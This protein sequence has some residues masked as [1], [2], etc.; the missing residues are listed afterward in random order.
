MLSGL[1]TA[2]PSFATPVQ[3]PLEILT[4]AE[5][6]VMI[7]F[8]NSG[9]MSSAMNDSGG[10][11]SNRMQ[12]AKDAVTDLIEGFDNVR[13]C[14]SVF[15]HYTNHNTIFD[16]SGAL[17]ESDME[18]T[19]DPVGKA[20]M[21]TKIDSLVADNSTQLS[22]SFYDITRYFRNQPAYFGTFPPGYADPVQ[23]RCQNNTVIVVT[24]GEPQL[25]WDRR[26]CAGVNCGA[27]VPINMAHET[28]GG[29]SLPDWDGISP[30]DTPAAG[31][32]QFSDGLCGDDTA[33]IAGQSQFAHSLS[34]FL[35]DLALFAKETDIKP[36][37]IDDA[38]ESYSDVDFPLQNIQTHTIGFNID[39]QNLEDAAFYGDGKYRSAN[40]EG[41]LVEA[42]E[43]AVLSA[44]SGSGTGAG[45]ASSGVSLVA[46]ADLDVYVTEYDS[47]NWEGEVY[48]YELIEDDV[49][50]NLSTSLN[51]KA[52][53]ELPIHSSRAL[54]T[55][56]ED[57]NAAVKFSYASLSALQK[58]TLHINATEAN[59]IV[60]YLRGDPINE[61]ITASSYRERLGHYLGDTVHSRPAYVKNDGY[62]YPDE[63]YA[64]FK[65]AAA[66]TARDGMVFVGAND[67]ILHA[68][69]ATTGKEKFGYVPNAV[70]KNL[71]SLSKIEYPKNH[72]Y[73]VDGLPTTIDAKLDTNN[74]G[75]YDSDDDWQTL[76]SSPFGAGAKGLFLLNI[77]DPP[78]S[79]IAIPEGDTAKF[80]EIYQWELNE[81]TI[82]SNSETFDDLGYILSQAKIA[83]VRNAD[84]TEHWFLITGNGVHSENGAAVVYILDLETGDLY[85]E[86]VLDTG[87]DGSNDPKYDSL[88]DGNGATD[89]SA[90][91]IDSDSVADRLYITTL[92]GNVWRFDYDGVNKEFRTKYGTVA[93]P[94]PLFTAQI[95]DINDYNRDTNVSEIITQAITGGVTVSPGPVDDA[96]LGGVLVSFGTGRYFDRADLS[97]TN[98]MKV[99][100]FYTVWDN[101]VDHELTRNNL[102]AQSISSQTTDIP[103]SKEIRETTS[104]PIDWIGNSDRGWYLDLTWD[105]GERIVSSPTTFFERIIFNSVVPAK[106]IQDIHGSL[107]VSTSFIE[108]YD[109]CEAGS[110]G[111]FMQI[112]RETG[113][114]PDIASFEDQ[115]ASVTGISSVSGTH[116]PIFIQHKD[117]TVS[118]PSIDAQGN[119]NDSTRVT[120]NL[121]RSSWR[122]LL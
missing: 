64:T 56:N 118:Y 44:V 74:D 29:K 93:N 83:R 6:N 107:P 45:L 114:T 59:K 82:D 57:T 50:G 96:P 53:D 13:F 48:S 12:I 39:T 94:E 42:L 67:G 116:S 110:H 122:R 32:P 37:G 72:R 80:N 66:Q 19:S 71:A 17:I 2:A 102:V 70:F 104:A 85:Q 68:F 31:Y 91:D 87:L 121:F 108:S 9:S 99:Q 75:D 113:E 18:C 98:N 25:D 103:S 33:C 73:F 21:V 111:W 61:G 5:P 77:S 38:G 117:G 49:T 34:L 84:D 3:M 115:A 14:M 95:A 69:D 120:S 27:A 78:K 51:W 109:V 100:S 20:A 41:G 1:I 63:D 7:L 81:D 97:H 4:P 15:E 40:T 16:A 10:D 62:G 54:F 30:A 35:D 52:S 55:Y 43:D 76:Y 47:T 106:T 90:I 88:N 28:S 112:D 89:V 119:V 60:E 58:T 23:F 105:Y 26:A 86:L 79:A 36:S 92:K 22:E 65:N 24:D 101:D 46:G 8:D 11:P